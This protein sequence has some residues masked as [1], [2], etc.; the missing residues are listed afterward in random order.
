MAQIERGGLSS[1]FVDGALYQ[2][3]GTATIKMGGVIRT[4]K[5]DSTGAVVGFTTKGMPPEVTIDAIDG[6]AVSVAALKAVQGST[7]QLNLRNGKSYIL[8]NAFQTDDPEIK[9]A[10][11][12]IGSVKFSGTVLTEDLA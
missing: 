2:V 12:D 7:I 8:T 6:P 4:P 10:E 5:V 9:L 1:F 3:N 11:A